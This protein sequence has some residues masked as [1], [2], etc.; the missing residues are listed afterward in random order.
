[1]ARVWCRS[2]QSCRGNSYLLL[3]RLWLSSVT[4]MRAKTGIFGTFFPGCSESDLHHEGGLFVRLVP[5]LLF[6][7]SLFIMG[8]HFKASWY[9]FVKTCGVMSL[10]PWGSGGRDEVTWLMSFHFIVQG[11]CIKVP[12]RSHMYQVSVV[13]GHIHIVL[14]GR[15]MWA[16]TSFPRMLL[17]H[18]EVI[19]Y[20]L[21]LC[22]LCSV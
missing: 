8:L 17:A 22:V 12:S 2:F 5:S 13:K 9:L 1:M 15:V 19:H 20:A 10:V 16:S 3:L 6:R 7:A 4:P 21:C 11:P 18:C 14:S